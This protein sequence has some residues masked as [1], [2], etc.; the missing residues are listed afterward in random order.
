MSLLL[1]ITLSKT[2]Q[3][4]SSGPPISHENENRTTVAAA[5]SFVELKRKRAR[6]GTSCLSSKKQITNLTPRQGKITFLNGS[7]VTGLVEQ[8][9]SYEG[10]IVND[11][12]HGYGT[13]KYPNGDWIEG[14]FHEGRVV[15]RTK[16]H[17]SYEEEVGSY[18][19]GQVAAD[20]IPNGFGKK[21]FANGDWIEGEFAN[22]RL[23]KISKCHLLDQDGGYYEGEL[24]NGKRHG[25]GKKVFANGTW[26]EGYFK[27]GYLK[28]AKKARFNEGNTFYYE[29]DIAKGK[30]HGIGKRIHKT[31]GM[32]IECK[33]DQGRII[34]VLRV[35]FQGD[36]FQYE[37]EISGTSPHG[38]GKISYPDGTWVYG[39]FEDGKCIGFGHGLVKLE[40]GFYF[41]GK[42][43]DGIPHGKGTLIFPG[44]RKVPCHFHKG[45]YFKGALK[46]NEPHGRVIMILGGNQIFEGDFQEGILIKQTK[47]IPIKDAYFLVE[48]I[49]AS[50]SL[51]RLFDELRP[52]NSSSQIASSSER[53]DLA[54]SK[55]HCALCSSSNRLPALECSESIPE[56][57]IGSLSPFSD[58]FAD[59]N[60]IDFNFLNSSL[61]FEQAGPV[62]ENPTK[63][64]SSF[65]PPELLL[66][67]PQDNPSRFHG[68][69]AFEQIAP[70]AQEN[71]IESPTFPEI[72]NP[73]EEMGH[74]DLI[75][76]RSSPSFFGYSRFVYEDDL[77]LPPTPY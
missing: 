61:I 21:G 49:E 6:G 58:F 70:P 43:L 56:N 38:K 52:E 54:E 25:C 67:E 7:W 30:P 9:I 32:W 69:P 72:S 4:S 39:G 31:N 22:D 17:F 68:S 48:K 33:L 10:E 66:E 50:I 35:F 26:L 13:L 29:G 74:D 11:N 75:D 42:L 12:P 8:E 37:G 2:S 55:D 57:L 27:D 46:N 1:S 19:E 60:E 47:L 71:A 36:S 24:F 3:S 59:I 40:E 14:V 62:Q 18:Y 51:D 64:L 44:H 16:R 77:D 45:A 5:P 63:P 34:K 28:I 65:E 41:E 73:F 20:G 53:P 15:K 23:I 76:F